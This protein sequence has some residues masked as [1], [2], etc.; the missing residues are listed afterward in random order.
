MSDYQE[1]MK[2]HDTID[3]AVKMATTYLRKAEDFLYLGPPH[4]PHAPKEPL[5]GYWSLLD[6]A[7]STATAIVEKLP[8]KFFLSEAVEDYF[9]LRAA[10]K[11]AG[12][13]IDDKF[14]SSDGPLEEAEK[15][16]A[17]IRARREHGKLMGTIMALENTTGRT[18]EEAA[19]FL[20]KAAELRERLISGA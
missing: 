7:I 14:N 1:R 12:L 2:T 3:R 16:V 9:G 10:M 17:A 15:L 6:Q 8:D 19:A 5:T 4:T 20:A 11:E 13:P 18:D